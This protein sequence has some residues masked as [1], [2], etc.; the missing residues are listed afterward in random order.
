[1][2]PQ[3]LPTE[4]SLAEGSPRSSFDANCTKFEES[5]EHTTEQCLQ[6][7]K[8]WLYCF[9]FRPSL[10]LLKKLSHR[11]EA[12]RDDNEKKARDR[13]DLP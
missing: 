5:T 7:P 8:Q 10:Q 4:T 1:M 13:E 11:G 12:A 6:Y 2:A 9:D 3:T